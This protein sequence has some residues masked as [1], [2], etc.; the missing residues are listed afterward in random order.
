MEKKS[1]E[2]PVE[3]GEGLAEALHDSSMNDELK[4]SSDEEPDEQVEEEKIEEKTIEPEEKEEI[5]EPV[6]DEETNEVPDGLLDETSIGTAEGG[7]TAVAAGRRHL[8]RSAALV[9][10]GNLGSSVL[11]AVRQSVVVGLLGSNGTASFSASLTPLN[12]F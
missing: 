8:V 7:G 2:K 4:I 11:G 10:I 6:A 3:D 12:N 5:V 9:S 1:I